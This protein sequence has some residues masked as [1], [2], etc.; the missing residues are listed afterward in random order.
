MLSCIMKFV[1]REAELQR[2][3]ALAASHHG[4]LAIVFGRRR[5]GKTRV[6]A[7]RVLRLLLGGAEPERVLCLTFTKAGAAEMVTRIQDDLARF[8]GLNAAA[9]STLAMRRSDSNFVN[10][11]IWLKIPP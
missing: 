8:A 9:L 2:L 6:L 1:N 4:G 5:N 10:R 11:W 7:D 3:D